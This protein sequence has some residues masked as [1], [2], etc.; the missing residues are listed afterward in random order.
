[1]IQLQNEE[2][3]Y[4]EKKKRKKKRIIKIQGIFFFTQLSIHNNSS[5]GPNINK[6]IKKEQ[7]QNNSKLMSGL[8]PYL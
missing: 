6:Q 2:K 4:K 5:K 8:K 1:M 3:N 7:K